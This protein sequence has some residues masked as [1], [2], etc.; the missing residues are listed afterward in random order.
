MTGVD[1]VDPHTPSGIGI[2]PTGGGQHQGGIGRATALAM[3]QEG[4]Q[5]WA[6]DVNA[7]L[8][9]EKLYERLDL[10]RV[11]TKPRMGEADLKEPMMMEQDAFIPLKCCAPSKR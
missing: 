1:A 5:V 4:A 9:K 11:F 3:A 2:G 6:T 8:L 10:I 7:E